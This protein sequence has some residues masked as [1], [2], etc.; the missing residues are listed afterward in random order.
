[1]PIYIVGAK[2]TDAGAKN[3]DSFAQQAK[4]AAQ[5]RQQHGGRL[6][7]GYVT[8][9]RYDLM[10]ITEYPSQK[11]ALAAFEATLAKGLFTYEVAEA[12]TLEDFLK[13]TS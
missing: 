8:F 6:I 9:G 12:V 11:E 7:G 1:M 2:L 13:A 4:A 3:K 10:F 5:I